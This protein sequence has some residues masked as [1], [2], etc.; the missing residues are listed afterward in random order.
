[1]TTFRLGRLL[2]TPGALCALNPDDLLAILERHAIGDW[3]DLCDEDK[4]ANDAALK[5]GS[6]LLSA[7][8]LDGEKVWVITEADRSATTVLL[9]EEY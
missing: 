7:Y 5:Q 3:G 1:M 4:A 8:C 2:A 9:P 6:R